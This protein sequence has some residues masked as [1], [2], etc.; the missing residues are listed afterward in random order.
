[1]TKREVLKLHVDGLSSLDCDPEICGVCAFRKVQGEVAAEILREVEVGEPD[2][3]EWTERSSKRW[4]ESKFVKLWRDEQAAGRD[5][6]EAFKAR[7]W[8]P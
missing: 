7:G 4:D 5:P 2:F 6:A 8:T 3:D 1:M